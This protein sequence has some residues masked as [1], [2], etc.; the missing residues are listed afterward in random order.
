MS[1]CIK[2]KREHFVFYGKWNS[3]F[4]MC[5]V[6]IVVTTLVFILVEEEPKFNL[7]RWKSIVCR[8]VNINNIL[9]STKFVYVRRAGGVQRMRLLVF[10]S[11]NIVNRYRYI[12]KQ[13]SKIVKRNRTEK[14]T[15]TNGKQQKY[16][17]Q[18]K[19]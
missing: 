10:G 3:I 12:S 13:K 7:E 17:K 15:D 2:T 19:C 9:Y 6:C 16:W 18:L 4:I 5:F 11:C 14:K 8:C 1:V